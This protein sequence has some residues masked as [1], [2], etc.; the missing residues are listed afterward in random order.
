[1][2]RLFLPLMAAALVAA[3]APAAGVAQGPAD[4]ARGAFLPGVATEPRPFSPMP[5]RL[6]LTATRPRDEERIEARPQFARIPT[7]ADG[8][9]A[10]VEI[11]LAGEGDAALFGLQPQIHARLGGDG[12]ASIVI[13]LRSFPG[14]TWRREVILGYAVSLPRGAGGLRASLRFA[15]N[16]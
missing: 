2:A 11:T 3:N 16:F 15:R 12:A 9:A 7:E 13:A 1:M 6:D 14:A 5:P 4:P 8:L 10:G